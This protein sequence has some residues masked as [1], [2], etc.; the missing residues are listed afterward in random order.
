LGGSFGER[1]NFEWP[2][3]A[4]SSWLSCIGK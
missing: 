1:P 4:S 2:F 3:W